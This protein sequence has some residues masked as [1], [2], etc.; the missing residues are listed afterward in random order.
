MEMYFS[1]TRN[2]SLVRDLIIIRIFE[3]LFYQA[4]DIMKFHLEILT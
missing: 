4:E 1:L 3:N 2:F